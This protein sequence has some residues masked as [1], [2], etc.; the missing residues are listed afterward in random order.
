MI[1]P[2]NTGKPRKARPQNINAVEGVWCNIKGP[3]MFVMH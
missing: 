1:E 2:S 3:E